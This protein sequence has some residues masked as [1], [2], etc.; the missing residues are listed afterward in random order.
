[1]N[2]CLIKMVQTIADALFRKSLIEIFYA[3]HNSQFTSAGKQTN[4]KSENG[5]KRLWYCSAS[6]SSFLSQFFFTIFCSF[7]QRECIFDFNEK[8]FC[9]MFRHWCI[10]R[11]YQE[12]DLDGSKW[13]CLRKHSHLLCSPTLRMSGKKLCSSSPNLT[14]KSSFS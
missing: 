10:H 13:K 7:V 3:S 5:C 14:T 6:V 8:Y 11:Q 1:M 9:A 12:P 4:K 2:E